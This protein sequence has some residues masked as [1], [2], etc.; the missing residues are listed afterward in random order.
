[1]AFQVS[2]VTPE[3]VLFQGDATIVVARGV[4][5]EVGLMTGH[6]PIIVALAEGDLLIREEGGREVRGRVNG[7]FLEMSNDVCT[8][9][10]DQAELTVG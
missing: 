8:I 3:R 9:L 1:M 2:V 5:G 6:A 7:G 10:A 4:D